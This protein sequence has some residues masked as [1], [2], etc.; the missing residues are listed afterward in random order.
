MV[1]I[2]RMT[3]MSFCKRKPLKTWKKFEELPDETR[4]EPKFCWNYWYF[5]LIRGWIEKLLK[6]LWVKAFSYYRLYLFD[7]SL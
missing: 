7:M 4:I 1:I 5:D 3:T 2:K 6:I